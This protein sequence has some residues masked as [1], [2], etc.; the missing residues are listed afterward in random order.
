MSSVFAYDSRDGL[1]SVKSRE[2]S[3]RSLKVLS[4]A[5]IRTD[6]G[7]ETQV[8]QH[9]LLK[10]KRKRTSNQEKL[11]MDGEPDVITSAPVTLRALEIP[12]QSVIVNF[13]GYGESELISL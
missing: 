6:L 12:N 3:H 9:G 11:Y 2:S 5:S 7:T 8:A 10:N 13:K 1:T 4:A